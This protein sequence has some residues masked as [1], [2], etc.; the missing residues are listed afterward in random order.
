MQE[1]LNCP[2]VVSFQKN[3]SVSPIGWKYNNISIY[4]YYLDSY[5]FYVLVWWVFDGC[6]WW[7][8]MMS[9]IGAWLLALFWSVAPWCGPIHIWRWNVRSRLFCPG[10]V[11]WSCCS[12]INVGLEVHHACSQRYEVCGGFVPLLLRQRLLRFCL[13]APIGE[14]VFV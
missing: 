12:V 6:L 1:F 2:F 14:L 4:V 13:L 5:L 10:L 9:S 11:Y 7:N 3:R 8:E